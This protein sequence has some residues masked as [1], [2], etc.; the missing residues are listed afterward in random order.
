MCTEY[1]AFGYIN[2]I[3]CEIRIGLHNNA[4]ELFNKLIDNYNPYIPDCLSE[5]NDLVDIDT[6]EFYKIAVPEIIYAMLY[7]D[8]LE[9]E[10]VLTVDNE[11]KICIIIDPR[12]IETVT[13][14]CNFFGYIL[15]SNELYTDNLVQVTYRFLGIPSL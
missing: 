8:C 2:Q 5:L 11:D 10:N 12:H 9:Y 6:E 4:L 15:D 7:D 1:K 3:G 14:V 13:S